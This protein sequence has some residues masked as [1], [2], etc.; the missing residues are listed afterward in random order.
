MKKLVVIV[1][2]AL[3]LAAFAAVGKGWKWGGAGHRVAGWTWD[4]SGAPD[5]PHV[6][7]AS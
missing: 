2:A 7:V 5:Q 6:H 4:E 1:L 3:S